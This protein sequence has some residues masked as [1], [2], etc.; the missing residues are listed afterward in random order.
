MPASS[1]L[2]FLDNLKEGF[3]FGLSLQKGVKCLNLN[4]FYED[5]LH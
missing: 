3:F 5:E 2:G 4:D 1:C